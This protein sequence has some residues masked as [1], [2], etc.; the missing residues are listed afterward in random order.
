MAANTPA[1]APRAPSGPVA[2][3]PPRCM[4]HRFFSFGPPV[5]CRLPRAA[6]FLAC[7]ACLPGLFARP[8]GGGG[9]FAFRIYSATQRPVRVSGY[10][11]RSLARSPTDQQQITTTASN[12]P[13]PP[14]TTATATN[15]PS[16]AEP[17]TGWSNS[18][19][20]SS[21]QPTRGKSEDART[22][23]EGRR[24]S[25]ACHPRHVP[26]VALTCHRHVRRERAPYPYPG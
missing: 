24:R 20:C 26:S 2:L 19:N 25:V 16:R 4:H 3:P 21:N 10:A 14:A 1:G 9:G 8:S 6:C 11:A 17:Q 23:G 18:N 12:L 15:E 5:V 7:F 13:P 22:L